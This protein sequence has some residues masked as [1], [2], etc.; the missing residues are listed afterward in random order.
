M[1]AR[2]ITTWPAYAPVRALDSL[3]VRGRVEIRHVFRSRL[4]VAKR[5]SDHL[6]L[7]A[8]LAIT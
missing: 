8:D 2:R 3:Y 5:A 1:P 4:E 7:I 6:P